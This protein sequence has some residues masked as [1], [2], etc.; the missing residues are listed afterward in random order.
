MTD[1]QLQLTMNFAGIVSVH[2]FAT[3]SM[4]RTDGISRATKQ[5]KRTARRMIEMVEDINQN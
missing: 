5:S 1:P 3:W 2:D 4:T